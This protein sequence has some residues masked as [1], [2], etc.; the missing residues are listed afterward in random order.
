MDY[1]SV[2]LD[3]GKQIKDPNENF[4][5]WKLTSSGVTALKSIKL[6]YN[7]VSTEHPIKLFLDTHCLHLLNSEPKFLGQNNTGIPVSFYNVKS[8]LSNS[9]LVDCA[10]LKT[11]EKAFED[12][13]SSYIY[14]FIN[15]D[16]KRIYIWSTINPASRFHNYLYS[17]TTAS[18]GLLR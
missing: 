6:M 9:K 2:T 14:S 15:K 3:K 10:L 12:I 13:N 17:W 7:W 5:P 11:P 1:H 16:T 18:Q 4:I 8:M